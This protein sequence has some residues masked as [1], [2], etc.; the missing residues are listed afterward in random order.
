MDINIQNLT[1]KREG[2]LSEN[3]G[4]TLGGSVVGLIVGA[5]TGVFIISGPPGGLLELVVF[6]VLFPAS[7]GD[8]F[9]KYYGYN[10]DIIAVS[11]SIIFYALFG[12]GVGY[13]NERL[14]NHNF[15]LRLF[16]TL[17]LIFFIVLLSF[18]VGFFIGE[19]VSPIHGL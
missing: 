3:I 19:K 18:V 11:T 17:F 13:L 6:L 5:I 4:L 10:G 2:F 12:L 1:K 16:L 15:F 8:Y 9:D 14:K 7:M